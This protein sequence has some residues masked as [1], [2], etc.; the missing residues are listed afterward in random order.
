MITIKNKRLLFIVII[1]L[2][3]ISFST[4]VLYKANY[5]QENKKQANIEFEGIVNHIVDGD[6]LDIN[7][8]RIRLA[9][10]NTPERGQEG[11]MKAKKLV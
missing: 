5:K 2:I 7:D 6:T 9:L 4:Y 3:I 8:H 11:Y 1:V 10:V